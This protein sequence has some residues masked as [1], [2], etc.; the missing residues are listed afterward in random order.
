MDSPRHPDELPGDPDPLLS[1]RLNR[2]R[3]LIMTGAGLVVLSPLAGGTAQAQ[4]DDERERQRRRRSWLAGDHHIHSEYSV[5]FDT[6]TNPPTPIIGGD[7][8]YPIATNAMK[9]RDYGLQWTVATDHGGPTHSKVNF[10]LPYPKLVESRRTVPQVLQFWGMEFDTPAADHSTLLIPRSSDEARILFDLESRFSKRDPWPA[11]PSRDTEL[12]MI[13]AL[14]YMKRYRTPPLVIAHHAARSAPGL[15]VYG[16]DTPAEFRN[17]NDTAPHIAVGFEGSPGHQAGALNTDGTIG[18]TSPRGA[19]G[20]YPTHGGYDQ[21]TARLGGLWDSLLG[22]GRRWWITATSDSHVNWRDGGV[23]F[24]P[25]EYS[26][27]YV[28]TAKDYSDILDGLRSGRIF[29]TTGDLI[30]SLDVRAY[31]RGRAPFHAEAGGTTADIGE[32][33]RIRPGD[34]VTVVIRFGRL[35]GINGRGQRPQVRRVDLISGEVTGP[36]ASR[37]ADTNPTTRVVRR[38]SGGDIANIPHPVLTYTLRSVEKDTY[39]RVRGT[40]TPEE[41]PL[42]DTRGEDPWADLWFYSNPIFIEVR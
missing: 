22:E 29:V 32:T 42:P 24:W 3:L 21:M 20:N 33:L 23:D 40:N 8:I 37:S 2:R 13:E 31:R 27:T 17:W 16:Q 36:A 38:F 18:R 28:H 12:K 11:D 41:E 14:Q 25:G 35:L 10:E 1:A 9:A 6:S 26:K 39:I 7:A 15:G 4:D 34:D 30:T 5:E 19:Y